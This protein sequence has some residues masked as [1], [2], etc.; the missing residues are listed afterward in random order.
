M[1]G[2]LTGETILITGGAG[3]VGSNLTRRCLELGATVRVL[4][5]FST[6]NPI[7]L[8]GSERLVVLRGSVTDAQ[9]VAEAVAGV[10]T[11]IHAAARNIIASTRNPRE[12]FETNIGGTL[13]V[14]I[15]G[16]AAGA[17]RI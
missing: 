7:N 2:S 5:D 12:D 16:R 13:N 8:P 10:P 14:L 1:A 3:F 11:I 9:Q 15:A 17:R 4:D 6:G